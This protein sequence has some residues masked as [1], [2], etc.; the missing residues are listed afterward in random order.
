M[1]HGLSRTRLYRIYS[2]M[3][4]RCLNKNSPAYALYGEKGITICTDWLGD[5]GFIAFYKWANE[6]GYNDKLCIDRINSKLGYSPNNCHWITRE[7]N[8]QK[9]WIETGIDM[10]Y[11]KHP[12]AMPDWW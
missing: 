9:A 7:E 2:N 6:H 5:D 8:S 4:Q 11:Q 10:Y 3:K 12:G 1:K